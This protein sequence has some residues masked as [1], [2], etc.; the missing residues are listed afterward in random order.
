MAALDIESASWRLFCTPTLVIG[1]AVKL[2]ESDFVSLSI[3]PG[4]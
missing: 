2:Y 4:T 1:D 3:A